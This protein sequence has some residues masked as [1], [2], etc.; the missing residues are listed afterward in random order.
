MNEFDN[1]IVNQR[2]DPAQAITEQSQ[3]RLFLKSSA[4]V[5]A[6]F[7]SNLGFAQTAKSVWGAAKPFTFES[8]PL[9]MSSD[10]IA[11]PK[12]Y[13]WEV[14]AAWGDPINGKFPVISYDVIN[15]PELS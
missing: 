13:R 9:S 5:V 7:G 2:F 8:V 10:G 12:G 14:L 4:A 6:L 3:R 15:T 1:P 11:V